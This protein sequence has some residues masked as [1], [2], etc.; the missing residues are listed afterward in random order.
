MY[1]H[2]SSTKYLLNHYNNYNSYKSVQI[3]LF[4]KTNAVLNYVPINFKIY[5]NAIK[6]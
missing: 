6:D 4:Y 3:E 1:K 5:L 2:I